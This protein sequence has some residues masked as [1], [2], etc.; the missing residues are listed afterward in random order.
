MR[1]GGAAGQQLSFGL[2]SLLQTINASDALY[3]TAQA[4][5]YLQPYGDTVYMQGGGAAGQQLSFQLD[6]GEQTITSSA[7]SDLKLST[8]GTGDVW[9]QPNADG[10]S[11]G[12]G[13]VFMRGSGEATQQLEFQLNNN[14]QSIRAA[15]ALVLLSETSDVYIDPDG[16]DVFM[17]AQGD[18]NKQLKF[19]M[20]TTSQQ[21]LASDALVLTSSSDFTLQPGNATGIKILDENGGNALTLNADSGGRGAIIKSAYGKDLEIQ[22]GE[23]FGGFGYNNSHLGLRAASITA[24]ANREI[25]LVP[26]FVGT[27]GTTDANSYVEIRGA[28][29]WNDSGDLYNGGYSQMGDELPDGYGAIRFI[30]GGVSDQRA[31][32]L[33]DADLII[34]HSDDFE[35]TN[36]SV[37]FTSNNFYFRTM[38]NSP[39][40][41]EGDVDGD[42]WIDITSSEYPNAATSIGFY[43]DNPALHKP[44]GA[45]VIERSAPEIQVSMYTDPH[46]GFTSRQTVLE[47]MNDNNSPADNMIVGEMR[48]SAENTS[49]V[50]TTYASIVGRTSDVSASTEDGRL[51]FYTIDGGAISLG[52]TLEDDDLTVQGDVNSLSDVRL[53]ENIE[54]VENGLD[55]V[56]QLRGVRYN[57]ID[58]EDRKIG[59][60]AQEVEEVLPEVVKTNGEGMKSVDYGKMVGVL[61]EAIKELKQEIDELKGK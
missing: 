17:R 16:G 19:T 13:S 5:M 23:I 28:F 1:G 24:K 20:G 44:S 46:T 51:E 34:G 45:F 57:K 31:Y 6:A 25:V 53:K 52:M 22:A 47:L 18:F 41:D 32:M 21:I 54:T 58:E 4:D 60:I 15:Q 10:L 38:A 50:L 61:I 14:L 11:I 43:Y 26:G 37:Y 40:D 55:L 33:A 8:S 36:H 56:S 49:S 35:G 9:L 7:N 2:Q 12:D 59:V 42:L 39:S 30:P 27:E 3:I 29:N 48:F